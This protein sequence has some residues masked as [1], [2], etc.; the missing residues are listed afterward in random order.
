MHHFGMLRRITT[1]PCDLF[2]Q[3]GAACD[4]VLTEAMAALHGSRKE[5]VCHRPGQDIIVPPA[6]Y[7]FTPDNQDQNGP[8]RPHFPT[9]YVQTE[10]LGKHHTN[11]TVVLYYAGEIGEAALCCVV[12][13][14]TLCC[15]VLYYYADSM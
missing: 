11:R 2:H 5:V 4:V 8:G 1:E 13:C 6:P 10:W 9:P 7:E 12:L 3:W 15:T 14:C